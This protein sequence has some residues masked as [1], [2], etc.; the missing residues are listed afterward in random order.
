[1]LHW[2]LSGVGFLNSEIIVVNAAG[3]SLPRLDGY[4]K[5]RITTDIYPN[6]S[7]LGGIY[8][9]LSASGTE[10][11]LVVAGDIPFL[12]RNLL[13]YLVEL[14][15]GYDVVIPRLGELVEPLHAV[16][17]RRCLALIEEQVRRGELALHTLL[18]R[19]KV[20]YVESEEID[21]FDPRHLSFFNINTQADLDSARRLAAETD[22]VKC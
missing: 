16:Y 14:A 4:S 1:L 13:H 10:Y 18:A 20:R 15:P 11:N 22:V 19:L 7:A 9:G 12:K 5:L 21:R 2:V 3:K 6:K 17:S 8:T